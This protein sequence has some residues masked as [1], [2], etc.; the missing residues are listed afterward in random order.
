MPIDLLVNG[1]EKRFLPNKEFQSFD[2]S[3]HSTIE[4][5]DWKFYVKSTEKK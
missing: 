3:K 5:M 1:I 4:I 2:I